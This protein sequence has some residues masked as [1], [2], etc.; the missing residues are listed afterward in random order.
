M[1][2]HPL[3]EPTPTFQISAAAATIPL[4]NNPIPTNPYIRMKSHF[5]YCPSTIPIVALLL[6]KA[7][8]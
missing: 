6:E 7:L 4:T 3:N 1:L 8:V 5:A 2:F